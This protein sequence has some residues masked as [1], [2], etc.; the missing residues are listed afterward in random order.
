MKTVA[1]RVWTL[2]EA[3]KT[4]LIQ[5]GGL[6]DDNGLMLTESILNTHLHLRN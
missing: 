3:L 6:Q 2:L 4:L 1:Q 5:Q